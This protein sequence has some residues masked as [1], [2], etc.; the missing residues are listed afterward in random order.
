MTLS[1]NSLREGSDE[2]QNQRRG[3]RAGRDPVLIP[4]RSPCNLHCYSPGASCLLKPPTLMSTSLVIWSQ[5]QNVGRQ[6]TPVQTIESP[7][8]N[9]SYLVYNP[10]SA[11]LQMSSDTS[12]LWQER[13]CFF[14]AEQ[15]PITHDVLI[16]RLW[17]KREIHSL[18]ASS[19]TLSES[20]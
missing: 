1:A 15:A 19:T 3:Q 13:K 11:Q 8:V 9:T 10:I 12:V 2:T 20:P 16:W 18:Q 14:R 17:W 6:L 7:T 4:Y 5:A